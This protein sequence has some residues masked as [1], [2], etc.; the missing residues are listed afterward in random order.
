VETNYAYDPYG[1][2]RPAPPGDPGAPAN[3]MG[4]I[5]QYSDSST[6]LYDLR[7]RSYDPSTGRF[8]GLDPAG[9]SPGGRAVSSYTYAFNQPTVLS[10]PSGLSAG[11]T[12]GF[13]SWLCGGPCGATFSD[14]WHNPVACWQAGPM[15]PK[16]IGGV[17]IVVAGGVI[18]W[19]ALP[20]A[21][22]GL[23]EETTGAATEEVASGGAEELSGTR[24]FRVW[25]TEPSDPDLAASQSGPWG[26]SWTRVDPSSVEK[27]RELAGL[28]DESNMGRFVSEGILR[29]PSGVSVT[30]AGPVGANMGGLD[31]LVILNPE[32]QID[33]IGV[34][35]ANPPF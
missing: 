8:L 6:G 5:G 1:N 11:D 29:D 19:E 21:G 35:G 12:G 4:Y 23:A 26:Q 7:A 15:L 31:E 24:V 10:D 2:P 9:A 20:E 32:A 13:E 3:P 30:R 25:G 34:Y 17:M 18:L 28:P 16:V 22:V 33:L 27:F 14:I